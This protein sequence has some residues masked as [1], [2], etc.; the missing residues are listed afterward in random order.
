V[1]TGVIEFHRNHVG[2]G[3]SG[4]DRAVESSSKLLGMQVRSYVGL[5]M[6]GLGEPTVGMPKGCLRRLHGEL[7]EQ[8]DDIGPNADC[9]G[10]GLHSQLS[11]LEAQ[12]DSVVCDEIVP[13]SVQQVQQHG[14]LAVALAADQGDRLTADGNARRVDWDPA[15]S[16]E[17]GLKAR[18][19]QADHDPQ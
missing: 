6:L 1:S 3:C 7:P 10:D 2:E 11:S 17:H 9:D 16:D 14:R 8:S 5:L 18:P 4:H 15:I 19:Q 13:T 12:I